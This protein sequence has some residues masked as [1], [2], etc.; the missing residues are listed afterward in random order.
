MSDNASRIIDSDYQDSSALAFLGIVLKIFISG[1]FVTKT[2]VRYPVG[3]AFEADFI[4]RNSFNG[5]RKI[6]KRTALF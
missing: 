4:S 3:Q 2:E 6:G 1:S 5:S